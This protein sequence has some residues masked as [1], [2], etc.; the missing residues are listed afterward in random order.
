MTDEVAVLRDRSNEVLDPWASDRL[1]R[2]GGAALVTRRTADNQAIAVNMA[3]VS[4]R[5]IDEARADGIAARR[6][7]TTVVGAVGAGLIGAA[8]VALLIAA[9]L[10]WRT[11]RLASVAE[12]VSSGRLNSARIN[13]RGTDGIAVL[14]RAMDRMS[15]TLGLLQAQ[16]SALGDGR[17][18]ALV[19][20]DEVPGPVG[21][22]L[23]SAIDRARRNNEGAIDHAETDPLTGLRNRRSVE[24]FVDL[25]DGEVGVILIDLDGFKG[26]DDTL[27]HTV[28]DDV[29]RA[30]ADRMR[31]A[32][33]EHHA[34]ARLDGGEF[35]AVA[36]AS[37]ATVLQS[38]VDRL[39]ESLA[40][41][42]STP[43]GSVSVTASI[44]AVLTEPGELFESAYE[45]AGRKMDEARRRHA[46]GAARTL[47][48]DATNV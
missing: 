6:Q 15:S 3:R 26:V 32:F 38:I 22:D 7:R 37:D 14:A 23:R 1:L 10:S 34:L 21:R 44:G 24:K 12:A 27:G 33:G 11:G 35:V 42:V 29:L 45:R 4:T 47:G 25:R 31:P 19:L 9:R 5:I 41:P 8:A 16:L 36:D 46:D 40:E 13:D 20:D 43:S 39:A 30:A 18:H 28:G 48:N 2:Q 17:C